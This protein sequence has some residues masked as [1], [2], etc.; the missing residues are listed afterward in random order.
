MIAEAAPRNR[1]VSSRHSPAAG[2]RCHD[3]AAT[4]CHGRR[5]HRVADPESVRLAH[6]L[7]VRGR[8]RHAA[9]ASTRRARSGS[10][11]PAERIDWSQDLDPENPEQLPDEIDPDLRL[12]RLEPP[13]A[14]ASAPTC[15]A[16]SR[17]GSS[18]S[19]CT[20]SRARC[21]CTAKIVQQVP[22]MDAKFYAATQVIDEARHVEAYS[23]LLHEKFELAYPI[24]PHAEAAAR[25]HAVATRA[26]TSRTSACRC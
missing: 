19:S 20:A 5:S 7:G 4:L 23:R 10:G 12:G 17:P 14:Q 2:G 3:D 13:D 16:T 15:A 21:V 24:T 9:E 22:S 26:G 25:R 18:R 11:T 8:P 6:A 1:V